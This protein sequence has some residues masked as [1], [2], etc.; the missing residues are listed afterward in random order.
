MRYARPHRARPSR[1]ALPG[2]P[3]VRVGRHRWAGQGWLGILLAVPALVLPAAPAAAHARTVPG[4]AAAA[5]SV[6]A[7]VR[8]PG[9]PLNVRSGPSTRH[10]MERRLPNGSRVVVSCRTRGQS[11]RG[12]VATTNTWARLTAGGYASGAYLRGVTAAPACRSAAPVQKAPV[13]KAPAQKTGVVRTPGIPLNVRTGPATSY[14]L[15]RRLGNGTRVG[16]ECQIR[17]QSIRGTATWAR[18]TGGGYASAAYLRLP[19]GVPACRTGSPAPSPAEFLRK[20]AAGARHSA[21]QYGIPASVTI[22]QAMLESGWGSSGLATAGNNYFGI[23]CIGGT[24]PL[25]V[26]CARYRTFE[27]ARGKGCFTTYASFRTYDSLA[28]SFRDHARLLARAERYR[29]AMAH[30]ANPDRFAREVHRAGYAT[31]PFYSRKLITLMRLHNLYRF[32]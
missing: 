30:K 27:C 24:G 16:V 20:A 6:T 5:A 23:K 3:A 11:I 22:A 31:D 32:N 17:G 4:S 7:T 1:L 29:P 12:T 21:A 2:G 8:T 26:G 28:D 19:R 15:E 9:I 10:R 13:G 25:A 14:R 18:F